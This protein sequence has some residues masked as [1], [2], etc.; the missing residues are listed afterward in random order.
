MSVDF[1]IRVAIVYHSGYGHTE[2]QALA[3][4]QG[5]RDVSNTEVVLVKVE[6]VSAHWA[7][8]ETADALIFGAPTYMG[9]ASGAFKAFMDATSST[10]F[11][12]G[13][14]W[15]DKIAAGFTNSAARSG[16]KLITLQQMAVFAAQHGMHWVNLGLP[17]GHNSSKTSEDSLN[18]LGF[19]LGAAAQS[20][21]DESAE[22]APPLADLR[23]AEH[24]GRRVAGVA[25]QMAMG[26]YAMT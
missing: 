14:L 6:D 1:K 16:D 13:G 5:A 2:R 24:L 17:P 12:K 23:T 15:K 21:A 19:F 7:M 25:K 8:L 18:R 9:S 26:R 11:G 22:V 4:A 10:V 3:V 20:N